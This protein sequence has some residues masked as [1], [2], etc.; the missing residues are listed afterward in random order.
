MKKILL[1]LLLIT[2]P[3]IGF[4]QSSFDRGWENGWCEG[5]KDINGENSRCPRTPRSPRPDAYKDSYTDGY[6]AGFKEGIEKATNSKLEFKGIDSKQ[7]IEGYK[8]AITPS[9]S[10]WTDFHIDQT[11]RPDDIPK[12]AP[13]AFPEN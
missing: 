7:I 8:D 9:K 12:K 13:N 1:L 3:M 11:N 4:G 6:N 10:P 5:W 2:V